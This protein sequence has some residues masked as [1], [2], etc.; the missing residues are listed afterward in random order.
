[1]VLAAYKQIMLTINIVNAPKYA[2]FTPAEAFIKS[3]PAPIM[4]AI[5]PMKCVSELPG[6]FTLNDVFLS[7]GLFAGK[8]F[9]DLPACND[10]VVIINTSFPEMP[11]GRIIMLLYIKLCNVVMNTMS[12]YTDIILH[13]NRI[14]KP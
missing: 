1:M 10:N 3:G 2:W 7:V 8:G 5:I 14:C 9:A 6:S 12:C 4:A 13:I 11:C